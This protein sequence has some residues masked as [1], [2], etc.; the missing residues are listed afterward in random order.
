[1]AAAVA[2]AGARVSGSEAQAPAL[3][4]VSGDEAAADGSVR[5]LA[6]SAGSVIVTAMFQERTT[7]WADLVIPG[8]AYLE[9]DGSTTNLEGRVQRL[10]RSVLPPAP[11]ELAWLAKLAG[12]LGVELSPYAAVAFADMFGESFADLGEEA[13]L[14][15][16]AE[17]R[18]GLSPSGTVPRGKRTRLVRYKPLFSGPAV[19]RVPNLQFQR[20]GPEIELSPEDAR[21]LGIARG[22]EVVVRTN[23][24][25]ARLRARIRAGLARGVVL[26]PEEHAGELTAGPAEVKR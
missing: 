7:G 17:E 15:A 5:A 22:D 1:V 8:T 13:P 24:T 12:Q 9:R 6:E 11:D 4:F 21:K 10:R 14:R 19:E 25:S 18:E 2:R 3:L 20:P 26:V 23:G 16:R